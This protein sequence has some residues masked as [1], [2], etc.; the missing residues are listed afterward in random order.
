MLQ[1]QKKFLNISLN[2]KLSKRFPNTFCHNFTYTC[3]DYVMVGG[4]QRFPAFS[5]AGRPE[6]EP[7]L[8]KASVLPE[9]PC[10]AVCAG[11]CVLTVRS[12]CPQVFLSLL[13]RASCP[14][15]APL[16]QHSTAANHHPA[17]LPGDTAAHQVGDELLTELPAVL[18]GLRLAL[19]G[20]KWWCSFMY[21]AWW[22]FGQKAKQKWLLGY[23]MKWCLII[24]AVKALTV[25]WDWVC[26]LSAG[27]CSWQG[28]G[29][30][31]SLE[32]SCIIPQT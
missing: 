13:R 11:L 22:A 31:G 6:K 32:R 30:R 17:S 25:G 16:A 10:L 5:V 3:C 4:K 19:C 15:A 28:S 2:K 9:L 29:S 26:C 8:V 20:K 14:R 1:F 24:T 21:G 27:L 7:F 12:V 18:C 23:L